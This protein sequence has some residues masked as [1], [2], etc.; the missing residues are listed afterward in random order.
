MIKFALIVHASGGMKSNA[1]GGSENSVKI[2]SSTRGKTN[3]NSATRG[4][5]VGQAFTESI[6]RKYQRLGYS[7]R[8]S[9]QIAKDTVNQYKGS[10]I[11]NQ[12]FSRSS[13]AA[14]KRADRRINQASSYWGGGYV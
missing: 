7:K 4:R 14:L 13:Y 8:V 1:K 5:T 6:S 2:A 10:D 3:S 11:L 9:N 12:P